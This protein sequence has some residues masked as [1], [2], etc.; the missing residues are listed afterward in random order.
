MPWL[1]AWR[2]RRARRARG[3]AGEEKVAALLDRFVGGSD[4][5]VRHGVPLR[6]RRRRRGDL[7]HVVVVGRPARFII[8]IET[9]A[10]RPRPEH[11]DQV[12]AN[13]QRASRRHFGGVPQCRVVVHP[14]SAERVTFDPTTGAA[15]MGLPHLP[16]YLRWLLDSGYRRR[17][18]E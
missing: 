8:A 11:L 10:E 14:N 2:E 13:A 17:L 1:D 7:D 6:S 3:R 4:V 18:A 12:R 16:G 15:R 5:E 9:K